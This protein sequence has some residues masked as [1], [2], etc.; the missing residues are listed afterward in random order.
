MQG[1]SE[2]LGDGFGDDIFVCVSVGLRSA[3]LFGVR[4]A[5]E[6]AITLGFVLAAFVFY[7]LVW[8]GHQTAVAQDGLKDD[9]HA[10]QDK[11]GGKKAAADEKPQSGEGLGIL[12]IP[13]L[14]ED[15]EWVVVEGVTDEDLARGPG[16]FP[17]TAMPGE[18]GNFAVAGHRATHGEP[19]ANLD[20]LAVDDVIVVET[21]DGW[22][23]YRVMWERIL[24]PS[25]T[26]VLAPVAGH[27]GDK[28]SQ[29]TLTLVTCHPRWGSSERLVIGAQL[30][31]RRGA[32]AGPPAAIA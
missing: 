1:S 24:S 6:L 18:V 13:A 29:R 31:E 28:A 22:L 8:T 21:V 30:V 20:R 23:T 10:A 12:H 15:W 25:A 17:D 9:F 3:T 19:F 7:V 11:H 32:A 2:Q 4:L 26:E 27:P 16:H 14:G 5:A